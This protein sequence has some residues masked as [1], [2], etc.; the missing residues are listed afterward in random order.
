MC[1]LEK[2]SLKVVK[3]SNKIKDYEHTKATFILDPRAIVRTFLPA[4]N[5]A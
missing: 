2:V 4:E 3:F 5:W 1:V